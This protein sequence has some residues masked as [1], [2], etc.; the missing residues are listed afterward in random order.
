MRMI[1]AILFCAAA[2]SVTAQGKPTRMDH[3]AWD[4]LLRK[5]VST[6]GVVDYT[7]IKADLTFD[8]YLA[9]LSRFA[10]QE[11]WSVDDKKAYWIN[12]YNAFTVKLVCDHLP[13]ESIQDIGGPEKQ[14]FIRIGG[15]MMDL[16]H[17]EEDILG[18]GF[19][20]P[21]IHFAI[22]N[23]SVSGPVLP[24]HAYAA[25]TLNAQLDDA[26]RRFINDPA[27]NTVKENELRLSR[28]FDRFQEDFTGSGTIQEF[29]QRYTDVK[30][31]PNT[32]VSYLEPDRTLNGK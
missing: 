22:T 1:A 24:N 15:E 26:A 8:R 30:L 12:V 18:K 16:G 21:R 20:D 31:K 27:R 10:P 19:N 6:A 28:I 14:K 29:L 7:G 17:I 2:Q 32:T 25:R 23:A 5:Y 13:L 3:S 11:A 9:S 4:M